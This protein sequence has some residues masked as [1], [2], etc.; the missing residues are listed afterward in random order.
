MNGLFVT[1]TLAHSIYC[2]H[3]RLQQVWR[4]QSLGEYLGG[5]FFWVQQSRIV[6]S[7]FFF[8]KESCWLGVLGA[9]CVRQLIWHNWCVFRCTSQVY[10]S[11]VGLYHGL[12]FF[13]SELEGLPCCVLFLMRNGG[14][15]SGLFV[16][17]AAAQITVT[18]CLTCLITCLFHACIPAKQHYMYWCKGSGL[19]P[20][21]ICS[22]AW[23]SADTCCELLW[24]IWPGK[25]LKV[26]SSLVCLA[27]QTTIS[28]GKSIYM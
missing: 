3:S 6:W 21:G 17:G 13:C 22:S 25:S 7:S 8:A 24:S 2:Y 11:C 20:D 15:Q 19:V 27:W 14:L 26:A 9:K 10:G 5:V 12:G 23:W 28:W 18:G 1:N 4:K 16:Q